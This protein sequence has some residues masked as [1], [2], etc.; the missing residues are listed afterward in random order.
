MELIRTLPDLRTH[1]AALP[2]LL[3]LVPTMGFLHEGHLALVRRARD[4]CASVGVSIFVNPAQFGPQEDLA[5]YPRDLQRDLGMLEA[6]GVGVVWAPEADE[7]YPPGYQTYINVEDVAVPLE[8]AIRP[9]HFRGV[10]QLRAELFN[11]F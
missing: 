8:G 4:E 1:L 5:R 2:R 3:G 9:G 11:A 6:A 10:A 7:V